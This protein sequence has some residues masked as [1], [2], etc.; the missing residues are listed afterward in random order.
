MGFPTL[1][2]AAYPGL[3]S[4]H[5]KLKSVGFTC[6]RCKSRICDVPTECKVCGL[7]VVSSPHL[8][9]SYRH[10]FPVRSS[11]SSAL[12][13]LTDSQVANYDQVNGSVSPLPPSSSLT[14]SADPP[15]PQSNQHATPAP[16]PSPNS[17]SKP[18]TRPAR[19]RS[20]RLARR[21]GTRA[22]S[23]GGT[24]VWTVMCW[25]IRRWGSVRG[26]CEERCNAF[27]QSGSFRWAI[28]C[29]ASGL[30]STRSI[31]LQ[32][33][34]IVLLEAKAELVLF[35]DRTLFLNCSNGPA[36]RCERLFGVQLSS[37][38]CAPSPESA[39]AKIGSIGR[40]RQK[41]TALH[42]VYIVLLTPR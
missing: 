39:R 38:T 5:S 6:P 25:C 21:G 2:H 30:P 12:A 7:T 14:F 33:R 10:L 31:C 8:A 37:P 34:R 15:L 32:W 24:F 28:A 18:L 1:V 20:A 4:C 27:D 11:P 41:M 19:P 17:P 9:R 35:K 40:V 16:S 22:R 36:L 26:A 23:V 13:S 3:C 29:S 42:G